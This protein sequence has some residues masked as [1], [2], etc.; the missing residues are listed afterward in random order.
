ML[1]G[2]SKRRTMARSV[3]PSTSRRGSRDNLRI[4]ARSHRRTTRQAVQ[5]LAARSIDLLD[6][7]VDVALTNAEEKR[8]GCVSWYVQLRRV[9]DKT[10]PLERWAPAATA[11]LELQD[12]LPTLRQWLPDG[13]IGWHAVG[14]ARRLDGIDPGWCHN[15][16]WRE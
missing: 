10:G 15:L 8:R 4:A 6:D 12:R 14:H 5:S 16:G 1:H 7:E 9:G 3:L 11:H 13:V 2:A